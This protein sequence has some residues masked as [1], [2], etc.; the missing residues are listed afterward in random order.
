V[1]FGEKT[2]NRSCAL[3]KREIRLVCNTKKGKRRESGM[4]MGRGD[5]GTK[6]RQADDDDRA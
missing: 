6:T 3:E 4:G 1:G 2:V 5:C